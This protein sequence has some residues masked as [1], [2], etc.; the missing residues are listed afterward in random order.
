[1]KKETY[2]QQIVSYFKQNEN[3]AIMMYKIKE[4]LNLTLT[5][6]RVRKEIQQIREN[7]SNYFNE[8]KYLIGTNKGYILTNNFEDISKYYSNIKTNIDSKKKQIYHLEHLFDIK[9]MVKKNI[10]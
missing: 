2:K 8:G 9:N 6:A 3:K 7:N 10:N 5:D 4:D 1:M